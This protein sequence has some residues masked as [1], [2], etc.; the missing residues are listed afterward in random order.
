[1]QS[2]KLELPKATIYAIAAKASA[3]PRTIRRVLDG[4]PVKTM[5]AER[6]HRAL[7]E[8]GISLEASR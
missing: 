7:A 1:M 4:I 3:D 2:K 8:A 6:I 5:V